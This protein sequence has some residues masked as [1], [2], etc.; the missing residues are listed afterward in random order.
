MILSILISLLIIP[1]ILFI[2][3]ENKSGS[4]DFLADTQELVEIDGRKYRM[5]VDLYRDFM[6]G[7][8]ADSSKLLAGITIVAIDEETFPILLSLDRIWIFNKNTSEVWE[9]TFTS[10]TFEEEKHLYRKVA[11]Y[12]PKWEVG[13]V[14]DVYVRTIIQLPSNIFHRVLYYLK[15]SNQTIG[16]VY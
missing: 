12:G 5:E 4:Y 14:V 15:S 3:K 13:G 6:T 10:Q 2:G 1:T 7:V 11:R 9:S 16:A 8:R